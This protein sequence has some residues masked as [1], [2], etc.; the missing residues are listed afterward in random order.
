[1]IILLMVLVS[2]G[3]F[4]HKKHKSPHDDSSGYALCPACTDGSRRG[5]AVKRYNDSYGYSVAIG[6]CFACGGTGGSMG[7]GDDRADWICEVCDGSGKCPTCD[8]SGTVY[9]SFLSDGDYTNDD[10]D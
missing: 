6:S 9:S 3:W 10:E 8:G 5:L 2:V 7:T 4:G 1:M